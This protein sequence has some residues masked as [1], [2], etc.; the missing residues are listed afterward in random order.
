[1]GSAV[2]AIAAVAAFVLALGGA[3][4]V[5]AGHLHL[6]LVPLALVIGAGVGARGAFPQGP[7]VGIALCTVL[8]AAV[9]D[10]FADPQLQR[11]DY[12]SATDALGPSRQG[13]LIVFSDDARGLD[14]Y[15]DGTTTLPERGRARRVSEID[16]VALSSPLGSARSLPDVARPIRAPA[17]GF[18]LTEVRQRP[19]FE[20]VRFR[21]AVPR[22]VTPQ[23][24]VDAGLTDESVVVYQPAGR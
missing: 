21:S 9:I 24:I 11:L 4:F 8:T 17:P 7:L 13:R 14:P 22:L 2:A 5:N 3:N 15:L 1:V 18:V 10:V 20:L 16:L 6:I 12:R 23:Q 19:T